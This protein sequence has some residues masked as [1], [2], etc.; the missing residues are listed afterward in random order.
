M[1]RDNDNISRTNEAFNT[2]ANEYAHETACQLTSRSFARHGVHATPGD[3]DAWHRLNTATAEGKV[4]IG[5][6]QRSAERM[7]KA[8]VDASL[9]RVNQPF[10]TT[11]ERNTVAQ[12]DSADDHDDD[13]GA[14]DEMDSQGDIYGYE[15]ADDNDEAVLDTI[16]K[17]NER[18]D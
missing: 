2:L 15:D 3:V 17:N 12:K 10:A 1:T 13:F 4:N 5:A 11:M 18:I 7:A 9:S 14:D 8:V 6:E 16:L